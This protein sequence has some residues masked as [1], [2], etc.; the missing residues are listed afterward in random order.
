MLFGYQLEELQGK[1]LDLVL[2][3][4]LK[5]YHEAL[6]ERFAELIEGDYQSEYVGAPQK[7][8]GKS[9][10]GYLLPMHYTVYLMEERD[11]FFAEFQASDGF[12]YLFQIFLYL[13]ITIKSD[14]L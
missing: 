14:Y 2:P 3:H 13:L 10:S 8:F 5:D 1:K 11:Q 4:L 6:L 12:F 7:R 9:K